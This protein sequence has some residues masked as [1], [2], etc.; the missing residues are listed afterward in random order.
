MLKIDGKIDN[1]HVVDIKNSN[2]FSDAIVV[3]SDGSYERITYMTDDMRT[4]GNECVIDATP[5]EQE[6]YRK[7]INDFR[8]YDKVKIVSGRKMVG[9]IK[10]I[11]SMFNVNVNYKNIRYLGF[12]DGTKCQ[13]IHCQ[14]I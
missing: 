2:S 12:S 1:R 10:T 3:N 9:E 11:E 7:H 6:A 8:I 14:I 4:W 13:A 5:L